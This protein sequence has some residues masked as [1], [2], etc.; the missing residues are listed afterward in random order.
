MARIAAETL[1]TGTVTLRGR[2][3]ALLVRFFAFDGSTRVVV[4]ADNED[5]AVCLCREMRWDF[6]C[7]CND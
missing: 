4:E 1:N 2:P 6:L 5:D 3:Q 7:F